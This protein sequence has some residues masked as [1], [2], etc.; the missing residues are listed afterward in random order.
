MLFNI[1]ITGFVVT[2]GWLLGDSVI[3]ESPPFAIVMAAAWPITLPV[4]FI[5]TFC[6]YLQKRK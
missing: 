6:D 5:A 3:R 1:W 2:L 4:A